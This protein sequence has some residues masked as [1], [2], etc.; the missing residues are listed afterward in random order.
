MRYNKDAAIRP[1]G[2]VL[3]TMCLVQ[4][5]KPEE[6]K[7][8]FDYSKVSTASPGEQAFRPMNKGNCPLVKS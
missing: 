6:S 4:V 1:A 3:H 7:Y 5:K 8:K 2:R